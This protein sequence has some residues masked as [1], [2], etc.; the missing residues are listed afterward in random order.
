VNSP[1]RLMNSRVPSSGS[2]SHSSGH[3]RRTAK[4]WAAS[5]SSD[6]T[7]IDGV[8]SD[9]RAAKMSWAARSARVIGDS[10]ALYS[11]PCAVA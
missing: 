1:L 9:S 8:S 4:S 3:A 11:T 7:G 2:T 10:S 6:S 5:A